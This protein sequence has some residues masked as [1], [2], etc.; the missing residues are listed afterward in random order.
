VSY[1]ILI[2]LCGESLD[3]HVESSADLA[4]LLGSNVLSESWNLGDNSLS[5]AIGS[6]LLLHQALENHV[7]AAGG[8]HNLGL[9]CGKIHDSGHDSGGKATSGL[10]ESDSVVEGDGLG[11][12]Y[13]LGGL[14]ECLLH[15][16]VVGLDLLDVA[17]LAA[18][19]L[20]VSVEGADGFLDVA[21]CA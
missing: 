3:T 12:H 7:L 13:H 20:D 1:H 2:D 16:H 6:G 14:L 8:H 19:G 11:A 15:H 18:D 10:L 9:L 17:G 21:E 5:K 4:G